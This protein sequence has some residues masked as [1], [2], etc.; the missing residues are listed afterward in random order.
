[1]QIWPTHLIS[2]HKLRKNCPATATGLRSQARKNAAQRERKNGRKKKKDAR[3]RLACA[4]VFLVSILVYCKRV[5]CLLRLLHRLCQL[6]GRP[7]P[8]QYKKEKSVYH[9]VKI[10]TQKKHQIVNGPFRMRVLSQHI[11]AKKE[12]WR[13]LFFSRRGGG[14]RG[15]VAATHGLV[16]W[17]S[18]FKGLTEYESILQP[19]YVQL[20]VLIWAIV[21]ISTRYPYYISVHVKK[22]SYALK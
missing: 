6:E 20:H 21:A 14:G 7:V 5:S 3:G 13:P 22:I 4:S 11:P 16:G 12:T 15:L 9:L 8:I 19:Y 10:H 17:Y 2:R 1:M 18:F